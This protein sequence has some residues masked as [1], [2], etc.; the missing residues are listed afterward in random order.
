MSE[1]T[2]QNLLPG[3]ATA[4]EYSATADSLVERIKALFPDHP[5][6]LKSRD[7]D[8]WTLHDAGLE[9]ADLQPTLFQTSWALA[10]AREEYAAR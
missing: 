1:K 5:E 9:C 10:K 3:S 6:L 2:D 8:P 4:A 7:R